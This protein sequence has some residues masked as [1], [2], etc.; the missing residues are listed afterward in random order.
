MKEKNNDDYFEKQMP[1]TLRSIGGLITF[2]TILPLNVYTTIE[3]LARVTWIWP[4]INGIVG[5][6]AAI[7]AYIYGSW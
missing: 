3:E 7:I 1:S 2:S 6:L 5:L 4:I